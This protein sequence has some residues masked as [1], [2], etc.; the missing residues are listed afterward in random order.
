MV[1]SKYINRASFIVAGFTTIV[2]F[3][4]FYFDTMEALKSFGAA[5][6][7]G[8]LVWATYMVLRWLILAYKS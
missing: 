2:S 5:L 8:G 3:L 1:D 7:T 4:L 6:I